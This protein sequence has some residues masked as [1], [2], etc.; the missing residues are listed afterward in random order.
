ME[1]EKRKILDRMIST[2]A[3]AAVEDGSIDIGV[4]QL[5]LCRESKKEMIRKPRMSSPVM[6][7]VLQGS[8]VLADQNNIYVTQPGDL[9]I[10]SSSLPFSCYIREASSI[11][12]FYAVTLEFDRHLLSELMLKFDLPLSVG[13]GCEKSVSLQKASLEEL[14]VIEELLCLKDHPDRVSLLQPILFKLFHAKIL[15][16]AHRNWLFSLQAP[17]SAVPRLMKAIQYIQE[18]FRNEIYMEE[19]ASWIGMSAASFNRHFRHFSS[20]SPLQ[21]LKALRLHEARQ[22]MEN[23]GCTAAYAAQSVGY[24]SPAHF[25]RDYKN[26]LIPPAAK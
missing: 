6:G 1:K 18:N 22:M 5:F 16:G 23:T 11:K 9:F 15:F 26:S 21:Y 12:P 2:A 17:G 25:S 3:A 20:V 10:H 14:E 13:T 8:K 19:L 24:K 7:L 4:P